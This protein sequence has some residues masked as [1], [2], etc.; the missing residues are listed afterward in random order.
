LGRGWAVRGA[1]GSDTRGPPAAARAP[2]SAAGAVPERV[3]PGTAGRLFIAS[4]R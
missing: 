4:P 1:R 3:G 2:G